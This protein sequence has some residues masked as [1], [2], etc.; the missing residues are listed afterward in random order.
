MSKGAEVNVLYPAKEGAKFDLD[1]YLATHMPLVSKHWS[2]LGLKSW[3]VT[4]F[5]PESPYAISCH[6][7]WESSEAIQKA[8]KEPSA[9][10]IMADVEN[11]ASEKP[12]LIAGEVV[13][14]S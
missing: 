10:E 7:V 11:F 13:G 9:A 12:T 2:G 6:M 4:K 5:G 8:L 14:T 3:S 1:Y